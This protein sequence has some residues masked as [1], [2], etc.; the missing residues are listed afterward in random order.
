MLALQVAHQVEDLRL[1]R[2]VQRGHRLVGDDQLR[3]AASARGPGRGAAAARRRTR[4]G[5]GRPRPRAARPR[6]AGRRSARRCSAPVPMPLDDQRLA[7]D[8]ADPHPRVHGRVGVLEHQLDLPRRSRAARARGSARPGPRPPNADRA[9]RWA[10]PGPTISRPMVVLPQPDSPTSPNVS[11]VRML[12]GHVGDRADRAD[13]AA[14]APPSRDREVLHQVVRRAARTRRS[15]AAVPRPTGPGSASGVRP[16]SH[17]AVRRVFVLRARPGRSSGKVCAVVSPSQRRVALRGSRRCAYRQRG[18]NRQPG[19]GVG[20]VR[21]HA[22]DGVQPLAGLAPPSPAARRTAPRCTGGAGWRTAPRSSVVST[23]LPAYITATR[24]A[25][26]AM[27]PR[28]WVT[29]MTAMPSRCRRLVDEL[30]D[31]LLD[32]HVERGRR[33]VGDEQLG[34]AGQRHRDHDALAHAAGE[35]VRVLADPL[36]GARQA[37]QV[38]HLH[39]PLVRV[40]LADVAVQQDGLGDLVADR[41]CVGFSEVSGSWKIIPTSLPRIWRSSS[42]SQRG[43]VLA[44]QLDRCRRRCARRWA[45]AA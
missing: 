6:R 42:G 18:A 43:D 32:R 33:L 22:G 5:S 1:D 37:D 9:A 36:R 3:A 44:R 4:A 2:H 14:A 28:S 12:E 15:G 19:G 23:T 8:R 11:P 7:Q 34:L 10:S 26:P 35:L 45:A 31:L 30:E 40:R 20:Q 25:R 27:T 41:S 21:R 24:S 38:E 13:L 17:L 39:R 29:R 16:P